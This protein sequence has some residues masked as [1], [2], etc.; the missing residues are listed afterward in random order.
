VLV[1]D[2]SAHHYPDCCFEI[3]G[4]AD[5]N[6]EGCTASTGTHNFTFTN[7]NS[8]VSSDQTIRV[9]DCSATFDTV[10]TYVIVTGS[11]FSAGSSLGIPMGT[12]YF[13]NCSVSGFLPDRDYAFSDL[14][15]DPIVKPPP[16]ATGSPGRAP[17]GD[18]SSGLGTLQR[19]KMGGLE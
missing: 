8:N 10:P 4:F 1:K 17:L 18:L 11:G 6:V 2:C 3:N 15:I 16:S 12:L 7:Y 13:E 9:V 19:G 5:T 14:T